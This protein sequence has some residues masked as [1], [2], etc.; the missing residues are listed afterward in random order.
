[1]CEEGDQILVDHRLS[2]ER[3]A[4]ETRQRQRIAR[5][6]GEFVSR[7]AEWAW[8]WTFTFRRKVS[9]EEGLVGVAA[10]LRLLICASADPVRWFVAAELGRQGRRVHVHSLVSGVHGLDTALWQRL[11]CPRFGR[12]RLEIF[13]PARAATFYSTKMIAGKL[14]AFDLG[15][16]LQGVDLSEVEKPLSIQ[17]G[18]HVSAPSDNVPFANFWKPRL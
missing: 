8:F 10:F 9:F 11:A 15:G 17:V 1:V 7:L 5:E 18:R 6:F 16:T 13:D 12:T 2:Q 3:W 14:S 4:L